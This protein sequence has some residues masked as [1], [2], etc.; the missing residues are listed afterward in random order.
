MGQTASAIPS[1]RN[2]SAFRLKVSARGALIR[3]FFGSGC[4]YYS[5]VLS[6]NPT[7]LWFSILTVSSVG[8]IAWAI[9]CVRA[10]RNLPSSAAELDHWRAVRKFYWLDVGLECGLAGAAAFVLA[11]RGRFDLVPQ[12][13]GVIVG[14]HYLPLGKVFREQ[15]YYWTGGVMV[16]GALGSLLIHRGHIRNMVGF[17]AVGLTLWA[18]SAVILWWTSS[19]VGGQTKTTIPKTC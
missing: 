16:V 5:V 9:I 6:G 13:L 2:I 1:V 18:T 12:A 10:T 4:L 3:S 17:A 15:Q 19:A 8:L 7:P 14:L 11:Q